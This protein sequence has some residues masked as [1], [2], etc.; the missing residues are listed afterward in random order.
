ME[1]FTYI[2]VCK[3]TKRRIKQDYFSIS[4]LSPSFWVTIIIIIIINFTYLDC[5]GPTIITL[6]LRGEVHRG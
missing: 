2:N 1:V 6:I 3:L 4:I 5:A